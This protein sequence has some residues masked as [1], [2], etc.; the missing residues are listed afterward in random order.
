MCF[1]WDHSAQ[2]EL[3]LKEEGKEYPALSTKSLLELKW[4]AEI[5]L[6]FVLFFMYLSPWGPIV[7]EQSAVVKQR[8]LSY[9][10]I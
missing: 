2:E 7:Q 4:M 10:W 6:S 1:M 3:E 9:C 5:L 8:V